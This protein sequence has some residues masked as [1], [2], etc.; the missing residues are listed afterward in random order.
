MAIKLTK[1][2]TINLEKPSGGGS[3]TKI[4][5]GLG[6]KVKEKKKGFIASIFGG[7]DD[8]EFDLDAIAFL[9]NAEGK[10]VDQ[11]DGLI[12]SDVVFY[13][14][15]RHPSGA[16]VHT[17]DDLTGGSGNAD[18]EQ[19]VV[20]LAGMPARYE[21]LLFIVNVYEGVKKGQHFGEV[22]GAFIRAVDNSGVE[23]AR[24]NLD[25]DASYDQMRS[26]IFAQVSR[27]GS[28]WDFKAIGEGHQT[29]KWTSLLG[30]YV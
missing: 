5:I 15:L 22:S 2:Q 20:D 3:L 26:V 13:N 4:T 1:G 7:G 14:N 25:S 12:G 18:D 29:D 10:V 16:V 27:S 9:L 23:L 19:I 21:S 28:G 24:Y 11:G 30:K 17:G 8:D 6:W